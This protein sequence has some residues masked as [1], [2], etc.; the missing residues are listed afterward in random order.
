ML[1]KLHWLPQELMLA[2]NWP[3]WVQNLDIGVMAEVG[4]LMT[5]MIGEKPMACYVELAMIA[6]G[7]IEVCA[8]KIGKFGEQ[9]SVPDGLVEFLLWPSV[10]NVLVLKEHFLMTMIWIANPL[11]LIQM[12]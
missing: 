11:D 9:D 5:G 12:A 7:L 8:V 3:S 2:T 1:K 10:V 6:D 4:D